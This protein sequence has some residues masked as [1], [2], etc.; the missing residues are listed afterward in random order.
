MTIENLIGRHKKVEAELN[1]K[2]LIKAAQ[3][4]NIID[5]TPTQIGERVQ[6]SG[7]SDPTSAKAM[8]L[9]NKDELID[10]Q[11]ALLELKYLSVEHAMCALTNREREVI[12]YICFE[13]MTYTKID[14]KTG[15]PIGTTKRV[16]KDA[17]S[18]LEYLLADLLEMNPF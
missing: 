3:R 9:I 1:I 2:R 16:K 10:R 7:T 5:E 15:M 17:L 12:E 11:I 4:Q 18:K 14:I 6:T 13:G 8:R